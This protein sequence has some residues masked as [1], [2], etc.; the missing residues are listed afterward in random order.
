MPK[1]KLDSKARKLRAWALATMRKQDHA[2]TSTRIGNLAP[3]SDKVSICIFCK[4]WTH[5][6]TESREHLYFFFTYT[7]QASDTGEPTAILLT[8]LDPLPEI[9]AE[10][11]RLCNEIGIT[12]EVHPQSVLALP[13]EEKYM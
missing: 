6:E 1:I 12:S 3:G 11:T 10:F 2:L 4:K 13:D 9:C 8:H 5:H 7:E